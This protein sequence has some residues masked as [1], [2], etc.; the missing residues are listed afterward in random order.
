MKYE[1]KGAELI[2][3]EDET[4]VAGEVKVHYAEFDFDDTWV[5]YTKTAVF[6][7]G[8]LV[9]EQ[10]LDADKCEIPWEVLA[11]HG[12]LM[13][14]VYGSTA[15]KT[16]PTLWAREKFV[17]YGACPGEASREPTP[18]KWQ[19]VLAE[20]E[21]AKAKVEAEIEAIKAE[22]SGAPSGGMEL[23]WEN[24]NIDTFGR[25]ILNF[26][27]KG[28]KKFLIVHGSYV[29]SEF[30]YYCMYGLVTSAYIDADVDVGESV[31]DST[32][33]SYDRT[34]QFC[35]TFVGSYSLDGGYM[36]GIPVSR[37]VQVLSENQMLFGDAFCGSGYY[38][39]PNNCCIPLRIYGIA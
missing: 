5:D 9:K 26:D 6:K 18:D 27:Q 16:R 20:I 22:I 24:A 36:H 4:L 37:N 14:G 12:T 13:V 33:E 28:H 29:E 7:R 34:R 39:P 8:E 30:V 35:L 19:Q 23:L 21:T 15:D 1:V 25:Q 17:N 32:W 38:Y 3:V 11:K 2:L 31:D 10:L